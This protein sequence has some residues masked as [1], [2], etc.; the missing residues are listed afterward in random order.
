VWNA[1]APEAEMRA[2]LAALDGVDM[3]SLYV[4]EQRLNLRRSRIAH[5]LKLR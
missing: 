3:A 4:R 5:I 2:V 1:I